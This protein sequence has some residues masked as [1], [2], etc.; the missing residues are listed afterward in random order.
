MMFN[1][2]DANH[3]CIRFYNGAI[4][5]IKLPLE[6]YESLHGTFNGVAVNDFTTIKKPKDYGTSEPY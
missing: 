1:A 2:I 5:N 6:I 3:S 4:F